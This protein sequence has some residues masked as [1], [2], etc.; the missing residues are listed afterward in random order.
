M[1]AVSLVGS[2]IGSIGSMDV[3]L[4]GPMGL[5]TSA[6]QNKST[7]LNEESSLWS[8]PTLISIT[9]VTFPICSNIIQ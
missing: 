1:A 6:K 9:V 2:L 4:T 3:V 7:S 8:T 5:Q